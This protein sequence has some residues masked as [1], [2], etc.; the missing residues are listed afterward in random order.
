MNNDILNLNELIHLVIDNEASDLERNL[1]F[2]ELAKDSNLQIEFQN[3]L[4]INKSSET[5]LSNFTP[6]LA[7]TQSLFAKTGLDYLPNG[8]ATTAIN[9]GST[10]NP[11][12][13]SKLGTI[14]TYISSKVGMSFITGVICSFFAYNLSAYLHN[15]EFA[16]NT[17]PLAVTSNQS[18]QNSPIPVEEKSISKNVNKPIAFNTNSKIK[19]NEDVIENQDIVENS[20]N[21]NVSQIE[22]ANNI[23]NNIELSNLNITDNSKISTNPKILVPLKVEKFNE[24]GKWIDDISLELN[25]VEVLKYFPNREVTN[26]DTRYINN[27]SLSVFYKNTYGISIGQENLPIYLV[28]SAG[29]LKKME[30]IFY[31][32][33]SYKYDF[34]KIDW[35]MNIKPSITAFGGFSQPGGL[36]KLQLNAVYEYDKNF[37]LFVGCDGTMLV[38]KYQQTYNTTQ[39]ISLRYGI[40]VRL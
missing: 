24:T 34:D 3:A 27:K 16:N 30:S 10:M 26:S 36:F 32:G 29:D 20:L 9:N 1:L 28:Q 37:D 23:Y 11:R 40:N 14:G 4:K 18:I 21:S 19:L 2:S 25:A 17:K 38:F 39:K 31:I 7:L 13:F 15:N 8:S 22:E 33:G 12:Y 5:V 35:L 6:P